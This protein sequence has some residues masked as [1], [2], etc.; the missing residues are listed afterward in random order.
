[1]F[2]RNAL[3]N[4][5]Q[6]LGGF[7]WYLL[8]FFLGLIVFPFVYIVFS[9]LP[10]RGYPL[11]RMAGLITTAWLTW[12]LGSFKILPFSPLTL[13]LCTG[14]LLLLSI[15]LAYLQRESLSKYFSSHWKYILGTEAIFLVVFLFSLSVRLGNPDLW[16]PWLGGEKPMDFTFFNAVLRSVYFPPEHPWFAGHYVNYYY[17]GYV[18]AAIPTKLLGLL[19]SIAYNLILPSWFA[20][21]GIGVFSIGFN[22][23]AGLRDN[24]DEIEKNSV[25]EKSSLWAKLFNRQHLI[26]GLPY[27][28]GT[29]ALVFVLFFGNLYEVKILWKYLP[30]AAVSGSDTTSPV[31]HVGAFVGG[32]IQVLT[33]Q[34]GSPWK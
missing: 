12:F 19:P 30:E 3:L 8:L 17:Y 34:V 18:I 1:M 20:M 2:D 28:A 32:A 23:V 14:L 24:S 10:D 26:K 7:A 5:N 15:G 9:W 21:T 27:L 33:G 6:M 29:L 16:H 4:A 13:W 22:L 11:M 25:E 31:E